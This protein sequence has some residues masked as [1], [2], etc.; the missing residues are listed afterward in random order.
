MP[1]VVNAVNE[2]SVNLFLKGQC[3][4]LDIP[5]RIKKTMEEHLL[6]EKPSIEQVINADK[7]GRAINL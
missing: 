1:A 7:W 5:A 3:S 2:V 6:I 4:F